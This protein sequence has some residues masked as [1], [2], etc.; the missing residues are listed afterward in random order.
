MNLK[1]AQVVK[2]GAFFVVFDAEHFNINYNMIMVTSKEGVSSASV[3][4]ELSEKTSAELATIASTDTLMSTRLS[5]V[6][7]MTNAGE[8][9]LL[10]IGIYFIVGL[11]N[12]LMDSYRM[13]KGEFQLYM[14]S[15]MSKRSVIKM[16]VC[17]ISIMLIFG[18]VIGI[19]GTAITLINTQSGL[20]TYG[21]ELFIN[22]MA[23]LG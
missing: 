23:C 3:V 19:V 8:A 13:R 22:V 10:I 6:D 5:T 1:V 2:T 12:N 4:S 14:L 20:Y 11:M 7:I 17:E 16:K 9:I 18:A 15:G 21:Y